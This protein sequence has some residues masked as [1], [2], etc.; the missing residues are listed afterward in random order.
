MSYNKAEI[1]CLYTTTNQWSKHVGKQLWSHNILGY[2]LLENQLIILHIHNQDT[3]SKSEH[4]EKS[5]VGDKVRNDTKS[6]SKVRTS[7]GCNCTTQLI[8]M[9]Q[10]NKKH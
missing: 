8:E 5:D 6:P 10:V 3:E 2:S 9:I 4:A 1:H 7:K